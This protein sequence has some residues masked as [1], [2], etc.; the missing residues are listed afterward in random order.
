MKDYYVV[1][2]K[3]MFGLRNWKENAIYVILDF[4][5]VRNLF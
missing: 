1:G 2:F 5:V 3:N 4:T